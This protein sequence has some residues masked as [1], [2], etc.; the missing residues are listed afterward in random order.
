MKS[1]HLSLPKRKTEFIG[2]LTD[3][4][5]LPGGA[6]SQAFWV[7]DRGLIAGMSQNGVVDPLLGIQSYVA[8]QIT[9]CGKLVGS[10]WTKLVPRTCPLRKV[11]THLNRC[12]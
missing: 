4:G 2:A 10:I 7:N 11:R 12:I 5:A 6:N 1:R 9:S 3:L 8:T